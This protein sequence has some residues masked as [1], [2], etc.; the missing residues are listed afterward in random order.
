MENAEVIIWEMGCNFGAIRAVDVR[1]NQ[2]VCFAT[3]FDNILLRKGSLQRKKTYDFFSHFAWSSLFVSVKPSLALGEDSL[4][5]VRE[6]SCL[7]F[8]PLA[9]NLNKSKYITAVCEKTFVKTSTMIHC[10]VVCLCTEWRTLI[11]KAQSAMV[12]I[13]G[14]NASATCSSELIQGI[15]F[16]KDIVTYQKFKSSPGRVSQF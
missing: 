11:T 1:P 16:D 8:H 6:S 2:R 3:C 7:S 10:N 13:R 15:H 4:W 5:E 12:Y 14:R 9:M